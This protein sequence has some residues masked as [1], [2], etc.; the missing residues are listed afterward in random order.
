MVDFFFLSCLVLPPLLVVLLL[1]S[2]AYFPYFLRSSPISVPLVLSIPLNF[3]PPVARSYAV[4]FASLLLYALCCFYARLPA[5]SFPSYFAPPIPG[6]LSFSSSISIFRFSLA[7]A[8]CGSLPYYFSLSLCCAVSMC[9]VPIC[10]T[11]LWSC[12]LYTSPSPRDS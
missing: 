12:L 9:A 1:L 7:F 10:E 5:I 2:L 4:C 8:L 6:L 11:F 3:S